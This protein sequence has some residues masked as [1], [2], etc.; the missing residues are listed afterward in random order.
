MSDIKKRCE[1]LCRY[2]VYLC[3]YFCH[4]GEFDGTRIFM[5]VMI[6]HDKS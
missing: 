6:Y 1:P 4:R 2:S 3:G 5:I